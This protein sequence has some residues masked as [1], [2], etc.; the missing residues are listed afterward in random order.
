M[1]EVKKIEEETLLLND[2]TYTS[3]K[4]ELYPPNFLKYFWKATMWFDKQT[5]NVLKYDGLISGPGSDTFQIIYS[6]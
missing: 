3:I 5:G 6:K 4:T 2:I 1:L